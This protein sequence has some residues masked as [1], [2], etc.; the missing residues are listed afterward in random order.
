MSNNPYYEQDTQFI[1]GFAGA[2]KSTEIVKIATA[3]TLVLVPTHKAAEVLIGKGLQNVY[4]IHSVLK[5]VPSINE[6]FKN[7]MV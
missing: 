2:G 5:L 7:R 4:T 6:N 1:T 3:T